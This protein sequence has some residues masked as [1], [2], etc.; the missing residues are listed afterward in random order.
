MMKQYHENQIILYM[1][2]GHERS[3]R[4][5]RMSLN[6][7]WLF[8]TNGDRV[9]TS[10]VIKVISSADVSS[11]KTQPLTYKKGQI[12]SYTE[13]KEEWISEIIHLYSYG[14]ET[15]NH[16]LIE[17]E[18]ITGVIQDVFNESTYKSSAERVQTSQRTY[19]ALTKHF[20]RST[21]VDDPELAEAQRLLMIDYA[22]DTGNKELFMQLTAPQRVL[23]TV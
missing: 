11:E 20:P 21:S 1:Y 6:R 13:K 14:V 19:T 7:E 16:H 3:G 12:I 23:S 15:E 4:T 8:L 10:D 22:L 2:Q 18:Q 9:H 17:F 5:S